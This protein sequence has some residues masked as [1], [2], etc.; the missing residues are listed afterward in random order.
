MGVGVTGGWRGSR[1]STPV[2]GPD[3][4]LQE[5][6]L[7]GGEGSRGHLWGF[8]SLGPFRVCTPES[9]GSRSA[10]W[11][12]RAGLHTPRPS[13]ACAGPPACGREDGSRQADLPSLSPWTLVLRG[14]AGWVP[15][16]KGG[17]GTRPGQA[18]LPPPGLSTPSRARPGYLSA[19]CLPLL[20]RTLC[21]L[22]PSGSPAPP[23]CPFPRRWRMSRTVF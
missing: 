12:R 21:P 4:D 22:L 19:Q 6:C 17:Q 13:T 20:F 11:V 10:S 5:Q 18:P 1:A 9:L 16:E 23:D 7:L 2:S 14:C 3:Q 15:A 8:S